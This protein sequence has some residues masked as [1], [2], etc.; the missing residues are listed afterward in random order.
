MFCLEVPALRMHCTCRS[1]TEVY[2][3]MQH[4][5]TVYNCT[6]HTI[7]IRTCTLHMPYHTGRLW[8]RHL[9]SFPGLIARE[10]IPL[11]SQ[12]G[13]RLGDLWSCCQALEDWMVRVIVFGGLSSQCHVCSSFRW[14]RECDATMPF[15]IC[16]SLKL[17]EPWAAYKLWGR[18]AMQCHAS[19]AKA[20]KFAKL[21]LFLGFCDESLKTSLANDL[22]WTRSIVED[23]NW[24]LKEVPWR[25]S[26]QL[27]FKFIVSA[28]L[29]KQPAK[30]T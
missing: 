4:H 15:L 27:Q 20:A 22:S 17:G 3:Y 8:L 26:G 24:Q 30:K 6:I 14:L 5:T 23:F 21:I 13:K 11:P 1:Y 7:C 12:G 9:L 2:F 29:C 16:E 18:A 25:I 28:R 10:L 19:Y